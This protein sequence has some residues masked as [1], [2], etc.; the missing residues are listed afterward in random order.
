[1]E[2]EVTSSYSINS[3][4]ISYSSNINYLFQDSNVQ[5]NLLDMLRTIRQDDENYDDNNSE[6]NS[7]LVSQSSNTINS[8]EL[9]A[10][11]N[12]LSNNKQLQ[13]DEELN[14]EQISYDAERLILNQGRASTAPVRPINEVEEFKWS[15][16]YSNLKKAVL[17]CNS[18]IILQPDTKFD[19]DS[20]EGAEICKK[21]LEQL[22][23]LIKV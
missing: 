23:K 8:D 11:M 22:E 7:N 16:Q 2:R 4:H 12:L 20:E 15:S 19:V 6:R 13:E 17:Y 3:S 14:E 1:M 5:T 10:E 9:F 21:F 18:L